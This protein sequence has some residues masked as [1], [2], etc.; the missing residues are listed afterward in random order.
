[1]SE[2]KQIRRFKRKYEDAIG[3]FA[4][5]QAPTGLDQLLKIRR[6]EQMVSL[7]DMRIILIRIINSGYRVI[8][9][10]R[11]DAQLFAESCYVISYEAGEK[12]AIHASCEITGFKSQV[13]PIAE[14]E[15][16]TFDTFFPYKGLSSKIFRLLNFS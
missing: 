9:N 2:I 1:L 4:K 7:H 8:I 5:E 3:L 14:M 12:D 13:I 6:L 11:S 16:I 15:S 10:L